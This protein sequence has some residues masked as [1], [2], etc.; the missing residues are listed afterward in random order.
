LTAAK[1]YLNSP[2]ESPKNWWQVDSNVND[3]HSDRMEINGTFWLADI[4]NWWRQQEEM[5]SKY[6]NLSNVA[7]SIFSI[8]PYSVG[9]ES[10][11]PLWR[12]VIGW[13]QSTTTGG[14]LRGKV[15]VRHVA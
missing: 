10:S 12:D 7:R 1:L 4:T 3:Y 13:T 2:F 11:F 5:H 6:P 14:K 9:V 15:I 8:I